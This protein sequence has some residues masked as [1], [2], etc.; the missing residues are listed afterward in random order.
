M[1]CLNGEILARLVIDTPE[2]EE[3]IKKM[4][5]TNKKKI[6]TAGTWRRAII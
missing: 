2:L 4:G 6:Y 3:R 1:R 5:I